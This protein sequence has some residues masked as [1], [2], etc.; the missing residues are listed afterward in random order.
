VAETLVLLLKIAVAVTILGVGASATPADITYLWRRPGLFLRSLTAM[1][2]LVPIAGFLLVQLW[3]QGGGVHAAVLVLAVSAGAP[4]LPRRKALAGS[5]YLYSLLVTSTLIAIV[6]VPLW[7]AA[8]SA[9]YKVEDPISIGGAAL[10]IG[11]TVLLPLLIG[12]GLNMIFPK[13]TAL[14]APHV[15]QVAIILLLVSFVALLVVRWRVF[16]EVGW[17]GLSA[18]LV[19]LIAALAIGH[20]MG[21][22]EPQDRTALAVM[23]T[24]RHIGIALAVATTLGDKKIPVLVIV[25]VLAAAVISL[26]YSRWRTRNVHPPP[27]ADSA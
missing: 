26:L 15:T 13:W 19:L 5:H 1:Y 24:T 3:P 18:L 8:L 27:V 20:W 7:L 17:Q 6:T 2:I 22:P 11:K 10:V 23:C 25:Y 12:M 9:Y 16:P 4:L 21:G 14:I